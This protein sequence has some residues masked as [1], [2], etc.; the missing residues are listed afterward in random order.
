MR[1]N[2]VFSGRP[3]YQD[4]TPL[5]IIKSYGLTGVGPLGATVQW[6]YTVPSGRKAQVTSA[7][8]GSIRDLVATTAA[9][10]E[11]RIG[12]IPNGGSLTI[13]LA[14]PGYEN[15]IG[16]L[17]HAFIGASVFL[18]TGDLIEAINLDNSTG[19]SHTYSLRSSITEFDA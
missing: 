12:I 7:Q 11:A 5:A 19:G 13:F 14:V 9:E 10:V 4:R 1:I 15:T 6:S 17:R 3:A 18:G 16:P 8:A 2:N